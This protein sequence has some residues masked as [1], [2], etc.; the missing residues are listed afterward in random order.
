[1]NNDLLTTLIVLSPIL[2]ALALGLLGLAIV[3]VVGSTIFI[4]K[5]VVGIIESICESDV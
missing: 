3:I 4:F 1:M 2:Y 5:L